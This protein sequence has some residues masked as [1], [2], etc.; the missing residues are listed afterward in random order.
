MSRNLDVL[1]FIY[2]GFMALLAGKHIILLLE[3]L[4]KNSK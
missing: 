3:Q 1:Y 4:F 2:V